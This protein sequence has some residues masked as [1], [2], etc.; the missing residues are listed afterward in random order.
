MDWSFSIEA[1][2]K[3]WAE[4]SQFF[5]I[6][7]GTVSHTSAHVAT[8]VEFDSVKNRF[9]RRFTDSEWVWEK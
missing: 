3:L 9:C 1:F 7:G 5:K 4:I 2:W 6:S 8:R